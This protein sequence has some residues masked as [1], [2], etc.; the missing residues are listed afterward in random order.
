MRV[1]LK[2]QA[3]HVAILR[4]RDLSRRLWATA[5]GCP[6]MGHH[7]RQ[8]LLLPNWTRPQICRA[9]DDED[10]EEGIDSMEEFENPLQTREDD[11][12]GDDTITVSSQSGP[13]YDSFE[14]SSITLTIPE[15]DYDEDQPS[16]LEEHGASLGFLAVGI[17]AIAAFFAF[18]FLKKSKGK[19]KDVGSAATL[20]TSTLPSFGQLFGQDTSRQP[21]VLGKEFQRELDKYAAMLRNQ[22][23][24]DLSAKNLA[25]EGFA[26]IIES[27]TYNDKCLA[28]D[29]SRNGIGAA[30]TEQ[31]A[32]ALS[33]NYT[34]ETLVLDTNAIRDE[35]AAALAQAMAK[36]TGIKAL[37]LSSNGIGDSGAQALAEMLKT[38]ISIE[39][40]EL[41]GNDIDYDGI[42]A[43]A[44]ALAV[45]KT[46]KILGLS[47]NYVG[48]AAAA[49]L[50]TAIQ[51]NSSLQEISIKG[52]L[53]GDEGAQVLADALRRRE[54]VKTVAVDFGNNDISKE[55]AE[56]I[57]EL[58]KAS[59]D[60][61]EIN[62]YGNNIQSAGTIAIAKAFQ[63]MTKDEG[64]ALALEV[65]D[66]GGNDIGPEGVKVLAEALKHAP[67]LK[68]LE[69]GNNPIGADGVKALVD[70]FKHDQVAV[71]N[72]KL[73]FCSIGD[74]AG[75]EALA[76][77]LMYNQSTKVVDIR[78]N[79][80]G[81]NGAKW[82]AKGFREHGNQN[83]KEL[84]LSYNEIKDEGAVALANALK[85]NMGGACDLRLG[86]NEITR[87]GQIALVDA[88]DMVVDSTG[89]A[90]TLWF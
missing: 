41:N 26:Y 83:L 58:I 49:V 39:E 8:G 7:C 5:L 44:E 34:L 87:E 50:A 61:K 24:V 72:L 80:L 17:V 22:S 30:G 79:K 33:T 71:E 28:A 59:P 38:N 86:N 76:D 36:G 4:E 90:I 1:V 25:D 67:K 55:G 54:G 9:L 74:R 18:K 27:F 78:G 10:Y 68:T 51:R 63:G 57:A 46:L 53:L 15:S 19:D 21:K 89:K 69:L 52:S 11:G 48:P 81:P 77:L 70:V 62:L 84:D 35:G 20:G 12:I 31:L 45:N 2:Y 75:P 23:S 66:L 82:I 40:L 29:F 43:I 85:N 6:Q 88:Q 14:E 16:L 65:L 32:A 13:D 73:S 60:L 64:S 47:G 3:L 56:A 37:I 42:G